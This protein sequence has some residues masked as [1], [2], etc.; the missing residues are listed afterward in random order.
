MHSA[1]PV[2]L[3]ISP[4]QVRAVAVDLETRVLNAFVR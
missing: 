1:L 2:T 3:S 4:R